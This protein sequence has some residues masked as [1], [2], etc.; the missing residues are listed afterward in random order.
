M[1]V[2]TDGNQAKS[3]FDPDAPCV[4]RD[5]LSYKCFADRIRGRPD[6][7]DPVNAQIER[8]AKAGRSEAFCREFRIGYERATRA[9]EAVAN[10]ARADRESR[11]HWF[12]ALG[13][14][15][16]H[17]AGLVNAEDACPEEAEAA[18][19]RS[20]PFRPAAAIFGLRFAT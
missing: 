12:A 7:D 16:A 14:D 13:H 10:A 19:N 18:R 4:A 6:P 20:N 3:T 8:L 5:G 17:R 15:V 2:T 1:A 9:F 11:R